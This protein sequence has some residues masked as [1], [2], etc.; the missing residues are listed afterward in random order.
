VYGREGRG[1]EGVGVEPEGKRP[2]GDPDVDGRL[3]LRWILMK[4]EGLWGLDGV[5]SG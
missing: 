4:L 1:A 3:I 5:G 2:L